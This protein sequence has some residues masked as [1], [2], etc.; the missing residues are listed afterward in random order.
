MTNSLNRSSTLATW[1]LIIPTIAWFYIGLFLTMFIWYPVGLSYTEWQAHIYHFSIIYLLWI[2]VFFSY[3]LFDWDTLR[4]PRS[5]ITR[6]L[7]AMSICLVL[8]AL[9]F[10]I[11]PALL[12]T[13][14]RF[15]LVHIFISGIGLIIWFALMRRASLKGSRRNV[16]SHQLVDFSTEIEELIKNYQLLGLEYAGKLLD[17]SIIGKTE[18]AIV[19]MPARSN[20]NPEDTKILFSLRNKGVRFVE[21]HEL[22]ESL[23]RTIHL[24]VL[25][26]LWF[27]ESIDYSSHRIFDLTKR[28]I[29]IFF[30]LLGTI[31]FLA[32]YIPIALLIKLTSAGPVLFSQE[33]VGQFGKPFVLYKYRTMTTS[34][35]SNT[36][37]APKDTRITLIGKFLRA[38]R[39]DE[40]P[41][42]LNILK[43]EMSIVGP[44]P[45]QVNIAKELNEQIPYYDE[46]HI[47]KPGLTGWAQLHV[48]AGTLEET[49]RKLQYDLYYIKHRSL[50]FDAEIIL[51]T[52]YNI[53]SFA[54]R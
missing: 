41:Q 5:F 34:G 32:T 12:I 44:R 52:I 22:Y 15:L 30:S 19:V 53:I 10:Y 50:L 24:S 51:K 9:Y 27:V 16:Y 20:L 54:G 45:E 23:T 49:K 7:W 17:E 3:R 40:L 47:V 13:P 31:V 25:S 18:R 26:E 1:L 28:I 14:R 35:A 4:I 29:D 38:T 33:R 6:L 2:A 48:Y 42:C 46:R 39:I 8:A 36:W 43:G 11:Q 37:T 21:F